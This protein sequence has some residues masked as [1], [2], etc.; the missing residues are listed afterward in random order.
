MVK[1]GLGRDRAGVGADYLERLR[2][3]AEPTTP[4][5]IKAAVPHPAFKRS[6]GR[7]G[8]AKNLWPFCHKQ[9]KV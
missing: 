7:Q 9:P 5:R 2:R 4:H 6:G 8:G 3:S 1:G